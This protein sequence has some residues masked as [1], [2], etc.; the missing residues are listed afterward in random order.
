MTL[1]LLALTSAVR[2]G[3]FYNPEFQLRD[4]TISQKSECRRYDSSLIRE[5]DSAGI[6]RTYGT[7]LLELILFFPGM[8]SGVIRSII[9]EADL[10]LPSIINAKIVI[11]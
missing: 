8:N 7:F 11:G 4:P 5:L 9:R 1:A 10:F 2:H 6:G 3:R